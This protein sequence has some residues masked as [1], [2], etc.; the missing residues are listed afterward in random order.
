M[1][2]LQRVAAGV[3]PIFP[4]WYVI[5][6]CFACFFMFYVHMCNALGD[7]GSFFSHLPL[8]LNYTLHLND[9]G[10]SWGGS[11]SSHSV[12]IN[13]KL[14]GYFVELD[15]CELKCAVQIYALGN[16]NHFLS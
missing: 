13:K 15:M 7:G 9:K 3:A 14:A 5:T 16:R 6:H 12:C 1:N 8:R 2:D 11:I 4:H 10:K